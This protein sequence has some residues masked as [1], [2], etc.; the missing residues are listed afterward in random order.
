MLP[1]G[2]VTFLF[3]DIEG[4]TRMLE[5]HPNAMGAAMSRH[6]DLLL[7][8]VESNHGFVFETVGDAVYASFAR[9]SDAV[10]AAIA[11]Q[12]AIRAEDWGEVGQI[13]VRMGLHTGDVQVRGEHYFGATLFRCARL[14]AIGYGGQVLLSRATR[15]LVQ[16]ALPTG[17]SLRALGTH[18]LKDLAEPTEVFQ[19]L[20]ADLPTEF[21]PLKSLDALANNLPMQTTRFIGREREVAAVRDLVSAQRLVTLSGTGGAGKTRLALQV[22]A[23]LV[24]QFEGGVWLVE[25]GP[26]TEPALVQQ[27]T[28]TALNVREEPGRS[29]MNALVDYVR[30]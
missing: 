8:A 15:D 28:A 26:L 27:A 2:T 5:E 6:H 18:R 10:R 25:V 23:D 11:G 9:A 14:M 17:A 12:Q 21:P 22:A 16:E 4:S 3:T 19:L 24:D 13:R 30:S 7:Q 29:L 1:A 20:H